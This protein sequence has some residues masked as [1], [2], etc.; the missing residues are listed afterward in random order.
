MRGL[1]VSG[2]PPA[3]EVAWPL[4]RLIENM[5]VLSRCLPKSAHAARRSIMRRSNGAR[6]QTVE[7]ISDGFALSRVHGCLISNTASWQ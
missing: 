5:K 4:K 3:E 2:E 1:A 6:R 7:F